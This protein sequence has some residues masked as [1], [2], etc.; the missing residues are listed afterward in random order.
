MPLHNLLLLDYKMIFQK[1]II[2]KILHL[3]IQKDM[4]NALYQLSKKHK[5]CVLES[6]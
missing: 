4:Y 5:R 1:L 3:T 2:I 6:S